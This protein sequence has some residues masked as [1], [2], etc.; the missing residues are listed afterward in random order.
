DDRINENRIYDESE[1]DE[2]WG[3]RREKHRYWGETAKRTEFG[4]V[5]QAYCRNRSTDREITHYQKTKAI[6]P[7]YDDGGVIGS[8][9]AL[10]GCPKPEVLNTIGEIEVAEGLPHPTINGEWMKTSQ[11]VYFS[12]VITRF[13]VDNIDDIIETVKETGLKAIYHPGPF[14]NWGQFDLDKKEFPNNWE[15]MKEC[16]EKASKAGLL[17]G[18]HTLSNFVTTN[19]A[20]VTPKPDHR[21]AAFGPSP[22]TKDINAT[23]TE[24]PVKK[25]EWF[26]FKNTLNTVRIGD[27]LIQYEGITETAPFKLTGCKRG[28]FGTTASAHK[29]DEIVH[30]LM[31]HGYGVFLTNT[32]LTIEMA[33]TLAK[34]VN[35]TGVRVMAFD[36]LE[37]AW[38]TGMGT[39]GRSLF[40]ENWFK[41]LNKDKQNGTL[42][43]AS[44]P[45]HFNWHI[46]TRFGWGDESGSLRDGQ[47]NYRVMN[48]PFFAR[49]YFPLFLGGFKITKETAATEAEW[50]L[51]RAAGFNA[52]F[53][54]MLDA[55]NEIKNNTDGDKILFAINEWEKARLSGAFPFELKELLQNPEHDFHLEVIEP[56]KWK[57]YSVPDPLNNP[58]EM[59]GFITIP[60]A[61]TEK[62]KAIRKFKAQY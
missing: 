47:T 23:A 57:L 56:G 26:S 1:Y 19:D 37:G 33:Q 8:K 60:L 28:A 59:G 34:F 24:I 62:E 11:D 16:V 43:M 55:V 54:I 14:E 18:V 15:S 22:L 27:E 41:T 39:Y 2:I 45:D 30:K 25:E 50:F 49:N 48:Q 4:S 13:G 51:A 10:F 52:G 17:I 20:Y 3:H 44:N 53:N 36:G 38:S 46:N 21:L 6:V 35:E 40:V 32:E 7:A 5:V 61:E 9:I 12:Y 58:G 31:D 42:N 29:K